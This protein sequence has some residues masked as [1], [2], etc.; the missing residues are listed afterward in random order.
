LCRL[1]LADTE[2]V[3]CQVLAPAC[4]SATSIMPAP[5]AHRQP[6]TRAAPSLTITATG[7]SPTSRMREKDNRRPLGN[8]CVR[9]GSGC[10]AGE[11]RP[12]QPNRWIGSRIYR[13]SLRSAFFW[14][15]LRSLSCT[16]TLRPFRENVESYDRQRQEVGPLHR[17]AAEV[18]TIDWACSWVQRTG[19]S[20]T[21]TAGRQKVDS[22]RSTPVCS[23]AGSIRPARDAPQAW[24]HRG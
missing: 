18:H 13:G 16:Q 20:C 3:G 24:R 1:P 15:K 9:T 8:E 11:I 22:D 5:D 23:I 14:P 21:R 12:V 2:L 19:L 4:K 17:S 6:G 10:G 7:R